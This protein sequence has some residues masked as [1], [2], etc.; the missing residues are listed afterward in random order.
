MKN[1]SDRKPVVLELR[2]VGKTFFCDSG[3]EV[4][5]LKDVNIAV[6]D[7][8]FVAITG[9][10]GCGKTTLLNLIAGVERYDSGEICFGNGLKLRA[11][12]LMYFM[13]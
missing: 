7:G 12:L 1:V 11:I 3:K 13:R 10:T 8:E 2:G 4:P 5:A 6:R 9:V